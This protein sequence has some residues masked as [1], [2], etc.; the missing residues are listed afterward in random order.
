MKEASNTS[1]KCCGGRNG[2]PDDDED[3]GDAPARKCGPPERPGKAKVVSDKD[4]FL[5]EADANKKP[6]LYLLWSF[7]DGFDIIL[8]VIGTLGALVEGMAQPFLY[9]ILAD[10]F[11][12]YLGGDKHAQWEVAL[13]VAYQYFI[14][15][16]VLAVSIPTRSMCFTIA[17]ERM[18]RR[19]RINFTRAALTQEIGWYDLR[20][21]GAINSI[22]NEGISKW[23]DA[24][25]IKGSFLIQGLGILITSFALAFARSWF[26]TLI[27]VALTPI[28]MGVLTFIFSTV[29]IT[30]KGAL[31]S[32][33]TAGALAEET[34][35][36]IRTITALG[37][38]ERVKKQYRM[39][40]NKVRKLACTK[41][42]GLGAG[43]SL[44]WPVVYLG[45][46]TL[47]LVGGNQILTSRRNAIVKFSSDFGCPFD[48]TVDTLDWSLVGQPVDSTAFWSF[49]IPSTKEGDAITSTMAAPKICALTTPNT[50]R[51]A[52]E[53]RGRLDAC[54][55][56]SAASECGTGS[57]VLGVMLVMV[58]ATFSVFSIMTGLTAIIEGS[59]AMPKILY[60]IR[61][62]PKGGESKASNATGESSDASSE[63]EMQS[64]EEGAKA[65]AFELQNVSFAYPS[66]PEQAALSGVSLCIVEGQTTALI[67]SSGC[68]KSTVMQMLQRFYDPILPVAPSAPTEGG[69]ED[70]EEGGAKSPSPL[71]DAGRIFFHGRLMSRVP[72]S[73]LRSELGLVSQEPKLFRMTV[74]DN[75]AIGR[76]PMASREEAIAA[77]KVANAHDFI[78]EMPDG[79]DTL[80]M[81]GGR[82]LSGGQKQRIAIARALIRD[83][84]ILLLDE[85]TSALD[86]ESEREVQAALDAVL[87]NK[88]RT[89]VV[90]AHRLST[91]IGAEHIIVMGNGTVLE[92]GSHEELLAKNGRYPQL[93]AAQG[94]LEDAATPLASTVAAEGAADVPVEAS[95][96][97][98]AEA[99]EVVVEEEKETAAVGDDAA[100]ASPEEEE[101]ADADAPA[102][103]AD[104]VAAVAAPESGASEAEGEDDTTPAPAAAAA[105]DHVAV[106]VASI[107]DTSYGDEPDE[108]AVAPSSTFT[109]VLR[110]L[111]PNWFFYA[112]TQIGSL[113]DSFNQPF[114]FSMYGLMAFAFASR[115]AH[116]VFVSGGRLA[117][118]MICF[119]GVIM[120]GSWLRV[121]GQTMTG[122]LTSAVVREKVFA[123]FMRQGTY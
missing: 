98:A 88:K 112:L 47:F 11:E 64:R 108:M 14:I 41:A 102:A 120:I 89:T 106:P 105:G 82:S 85:A 80:V 79:Y 123:A 74:L 42:S 114:C 4:F 48:G 115:N 69:G 71:S 100:A 95:E 28:Q 18:M 81:E 66:R 110:L 83:P 26:L 1:P 17:S 58:F 37:G 86:T 40:L 60:L 92:Q 109:R 94:L 5:D 78:T 67:G 99:V 2:P 84:P 23:Q 24:V 27:F 6:P 101:A 107:A 122:E 29:L 56:G 91:I 33:A 52:Y 15:G 75:I 65:N 76:T 116:S 44:F 55:T 22:M 54:Y 87:T 72:V 46:A 16:A 121:Y 49:A 96:A 20:D 21:S 8:L 50:T 59:A 35:T 68:G 30:T 10:F 31:K 61:R 70:E 111:L 45:Y 51:C 13:S 53:C 118:M 77:A 104:E 3:G 63:V 113:I 25:G 117:A 9:Y 34:L 97:G 93:L 90:I 39:E 119:S 62:E 32:Y 12:A 57:D 36:G 73:A 7:A 43:F 38:N 103:V 19:V